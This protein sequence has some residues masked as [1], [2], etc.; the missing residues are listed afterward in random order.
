MHNHA[1]IADNRILR[2]EDDM[3][4]HT[5]ILGGASSGKSSYAERMA[6]AGSDSPYYIATSQAWDEE[7]RKR[8]DRHKARRGPQWST[9]EEPL[10][11]EEAIQEADK[12]GGLV[13]VDCLT[14]WIT[15]LMVSDADDHIIHARFNALTDMVP[16]LNCRVI[17]VSNEVGMGIVP[18]NEMARRFRDLTGNLHQQ[19]AR[20]C[21]NVIMVAAGLPLALKGTAP[22]L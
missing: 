5:F 22:A 14:L 20:V 18:E 19:L 9:I 8:I 11:L 2:Y 16:K 17:M 10:G 3:P 21:D 15:N 6:L 1:P 12:P 13:L 4:E 7:M